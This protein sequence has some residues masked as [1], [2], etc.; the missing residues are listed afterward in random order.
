[1]NL[2]KWLICSLLPTFLLAC[3]HTPARTKTLN[4]FTPI[5]QPNYA[6][7]PF[8]TQSLIVI[9]PGHG[10]K[11]FGSEAAKTTTEKELNLKTSK[12]VAHYLQQMGFPVAMTRIDDRF[13]ALQS[14]ADMA[15]DENAILFLSV[16]YNSAPSPSA[17][18][19][20][21]FY[22]GGDKKT[23][24]TAASKAFA[25]TILESVIMETDAKSRGVK[26][27]NLA[28]IRETQM[29]AILIECG[30]LTNAKER[31]RIL[32]LNY[33][34]KLAKGIA[35]GVRDYLRNTANEK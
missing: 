26:D 12:F 33:R 11:D 13:I 23:K 19:I 9:D 7:A 15:N 32:D 21:V 30:F 3:S 17:E 27:G 35:L 31:A 29:P 2:H 1:M 24:R 34:K 4:A 5:A 16:H 6:N 28:V 10:G 8:K 20:E 22:Y 25:Q 14:R 18:G